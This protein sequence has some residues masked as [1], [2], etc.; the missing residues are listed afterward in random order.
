MPEKRQRPVEQTP[1]NS[2]NQKSYKWSWPL[3]LLHPGALTAIS[4]GKTPF[5]TGAL[6]R[7]ESAASQSKWR[8]IRTNVIF[9][10][11]IHCLALTESPPADSVMSS[12]TGCSKGL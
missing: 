10:F 7:P 11:Q 8:F 9:R 5:A 12:I 2:S 3:F 1:Q 4:A 6:S